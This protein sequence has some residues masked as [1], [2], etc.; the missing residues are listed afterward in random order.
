[1]LT[2]CSNSANIRRSNIS[3]FVML[4]IVMTFCAMK[5]IIVDDLQDWG[6]ETPRDVSRYILPAENSTILSPQLPDQKVDFLLVVTSDP[7]H[8][9]RRDA[10]RRT[11][12]SSQNEDSP[13]KLATIFLMGLSSDPQVRVFSI[14]FFIYFWPSQ[15]TR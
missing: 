9:A 13:L 1:M 2:M 6:Q 12:G 3:K 15:I 10:I 4:V 14:L 5:V 11:W 8:V 7:R